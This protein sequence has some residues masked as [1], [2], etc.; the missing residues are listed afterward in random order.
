MGSP[1]AKHRSAIAET[2]SNRAAGRAADIQPASAPTGYPMPA[3]AHQR[4]CAWA[5]RAQRQSASAGC[6]PALFDRW[7]RRLAD[8]DLAAGRAASVSLRLRGVLTWSSYAARPG[9]APCVRLRSPDLPPG[10]RGQ[11]ACIYTSFF[12]IC[13]SS[14]S[15]TVSGT[16]TRCDLRKKQSISVSASR[17]SRTTG[18]MGP[19]VCLSLRLGTS[20]LLSREFQRRSTWGPRS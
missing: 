5:G 8:T 6:R 3:R 20:D 1:F 11:R 7:C 13:S 9:H 16:M 15:R 14:I 18:R 19:A 4:V 10:G 2:T 12:A 17:S